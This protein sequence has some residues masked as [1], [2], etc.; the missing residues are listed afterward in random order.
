MRL[1][2]HRGASARWP[3][4]SR[5][6]I[7]GALEEGAEALEVDLRLTADGLLVLSHDPD[8]RRC[9]GDRRRVVEVR[10]AELATLNV[11]RGRPDLQPEAP[12]RLEP[13]LELWP[14]D[15][16]L[17][18]ELKEGPEQVA[19]LRRA[20]AGRTRE[21]HVISFR[22]DT[23]KALRQ[24]DP[25]RPVLW[26]RQGRR[27]VSARTL[28]G[29]IH[30]CRDEGWQGLDLDHRL[31]T[32]EVCATVRRAG[33]ELGVWTVDD[34]ARARQLATW[35]VQWLTTNTPDALRMVT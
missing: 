18:L 4:H 28:A 26:L 1:V 6:A 19:P 15:R 35:S 32:A 14:A 22:A 16:A 31:L 24:E 21:V 11:C 5:A 7:R 13:L 30:R 17:F 12:L 20:L 10:A 8:W 29:W 23:L 2:A 3:E 27:P 9:C 25:Q 34:P 33:L